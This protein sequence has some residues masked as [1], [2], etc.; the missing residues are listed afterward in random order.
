[1][2]RR[3][4]LVALALA[5]A[6]CAKL[7]S[8]GSS[9]RR[10]STPPG[11]VYLTRFQTMQLLGDFNGWAID[12]L[13]H[14]KMTL[15]ADWTWVKTVHLAS[16]SIMFK[17]VPNQTW[18]L[19]YGTP[20]DDHGALEGYALPNQSGTG[21]HIDAF[22]PEAGYWTF[23][24]HEDNGYYRI[25][26]AEGPPGGIAGRVVFADD[27][28]PP[29]PQATVHAYNTSWAEMASATTDTLT[30]EYTLTGLEAGTYSVVATAPG[31]RPDTLTGIQVQ[32][33]VVSVEPLVLEPLGGPIVN[34]VIDGVISP[35]EDWTLLDSSTVEAPEGA[36]LRALYAAADAQYLYLALETRNTANWGVAYG[37][38]LD[39][40]SG[41][42]STQAGQDAWE[43]LVNF[44][45]AI[46]VEYELYLHWNDGTQSVDAVN[47]CR[48]TGSG[49]DYDD[50]WTEGE[51]YAY[52]GDATQGL[53]VLEFRIPW[54][55]IGG[56]PTGTAQ[57]L[58]WV[59][60]NDP[61]SSAVDVIPFSP[62]IQDHQDE[63]TDLDT[64][65]TALPLPVPAR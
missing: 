14:T 58:A 41:G 20:D 59:A 54:D 5:L 34:I 52:T 3:I 57:G 37:F 29:Y 16:Q 17:F 31:Y 15:V 56:L 21:N 32:D 46:A 50:Q 22:I 43:R 8:P 9:A 11:Q 48:F 27:S 45:D 36:R 19:A 64:L 4:L 38:G 61:G 60:G 10:V 18:D 35:E 47:L 53:A 63:W 30:G 23:E 55:R 65:D 62:A 7:L 1:M 6:G 2:N 49:W 44:T 26:R 13:E 24:F 28:V 25:Y 33:Q 42:F 51:D 12:D 39:L 40:A